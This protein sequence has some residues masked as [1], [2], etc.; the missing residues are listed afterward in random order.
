MI[1]RPSPTTGPMGQ[2]LLLEGMPQ[3]HPERPPPTRRAYCAGPGQP[4]HTL[5][6]RHAPLRHRPRLAHRLPTAAL[7]TGPRPGRGRLVRAAAHHC[8]RASLRRPRRSDHRGPGR[9]TPSSS[10][11]RRQLLD[12]RCRTGA[13][14]YWAIASARPET[15]NFRWSGNLDSGA[16][17]RTDAAR[18]VLARPWSTRAAAVD[19]VVA[20]RP[21]R[22]PKG[23]GESGRTGSG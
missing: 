22:W 16:E 23:L 13:P 5:D 11:T 9:P 10:P 3:P 18:T 21:V 14:K 7:R 20:R 8:G 2:K 15:P 1:Y 4:P 17:Q 19:A 6:R 12:P